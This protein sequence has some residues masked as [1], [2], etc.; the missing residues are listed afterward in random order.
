[1]LRFAATLAMLCV[2]KGQEAKIPADAALE[3]QVCR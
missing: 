3:E 2:A 1:M